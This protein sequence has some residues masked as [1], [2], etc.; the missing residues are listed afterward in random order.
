MVSKKFR[1]EF[2]EVMQSNTGCAVIMAGSDSD[3]NHIDEVVKSLQKYEIPFDIRIFSAH[4]QP[5]ELEAVIREYNEV[6]GS[7]AYVAVAGGLDA[8]SGTLSYHSFGPVIS[9]PPDG[10]ENRTCLLNPPGSSNSTIYRSTNV[11]RFI[12]QMYSGVNPKFRELLGKENVIKINS[13]READV[14]FQRMYGSGSD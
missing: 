7:V 13:L 11:G 5:S 8:L 14:N 2:R 4:K 10:L 12:A 6:S 9:C 1:E 3:K